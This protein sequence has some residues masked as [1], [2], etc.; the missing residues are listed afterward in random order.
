MDLH[1]VNINFGRFQCRTVHKQ[2]YLPLFPHSCSTSKLRIFKIFLRFYVE[3]YF[4]FHII[5]SQALS[6]YNSLTNCWELSE[7]HLKHRWRKSLL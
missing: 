4:S 5:F 6:T 2:A 3:I 7:K 1:K